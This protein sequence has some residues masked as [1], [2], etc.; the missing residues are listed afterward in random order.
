MI[1]RKFQYILMGAGLTLVVI[2]GA[3]A[4]LLLPAQAS[5][6]RT[7]PMNKVQPQV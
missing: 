5:S 7:A 4:I 1:Q 2:L 6:V 3:F